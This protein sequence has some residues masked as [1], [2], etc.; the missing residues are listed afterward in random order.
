[1]KKSLILKK[2]EISHYEG[3]TIDQVLNY[4]ADEE[5]IPPFT[6]IDTY[7]YNTVNNLC[8]VGFHLID[9]NIEDKDKRIVASLDFNYVTVDGYDDSEDIHVWIEKK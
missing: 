3:N 7:R 8:M 2:S 4:L 1:M 6:D 5:L 9:N